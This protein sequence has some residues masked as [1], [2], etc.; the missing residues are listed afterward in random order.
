MSNS[1]DFALEEKMKHLYSHSWAALYYF[2][3]ESSEK[4]FQ[5]LLLRAWLVTITKDGFTQANSI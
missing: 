3:W 4:T 5:L 2:N 1:E